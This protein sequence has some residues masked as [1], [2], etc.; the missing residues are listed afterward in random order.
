MD[1]RDTSMAEGASAAAPTLADQ[2]SKLYEL[3]AGYHAT[4]LLEIARELGAW[5]HRRAGSRRSLRG[6]RAERG[7]TEGG[8]GVRRG[9]QFPRS[10]RDRPC[11]EGGGVRRGGAGTEARWQVPDLRR[12]LPGGRRGAAHDADP[13]RR[14]GA[15]VRGHLGQRG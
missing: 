15:V 13:L 11:L 4:N 9:H 14:A 1:R 10:A 7:S 2:V 6:P 3:V 8:W 5:A 12:G